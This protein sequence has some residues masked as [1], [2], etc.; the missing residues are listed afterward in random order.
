MSNE[1][2]NAKLF[3]Q[4]LQKTIDAIS[5]HSFRPNQ[6]TQKCSKENLFNSNTKRARL[7]L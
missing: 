7:M 1:N 3:N 2:V 5:N 6:M 4:I